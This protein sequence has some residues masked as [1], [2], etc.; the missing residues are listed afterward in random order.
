[1]KKKKNNKPKVKVDLKK[2]ANAIRKEEGKEKET[3][4]DS[5][6]EEVSELESEVMDNVPVNFDEIRRNFEPV[7][8]PVLEPVEDAPRE[9]R[10]VR[11]DFQPILDGR[12]NENENDLFR[13][14]IQDKEEQPKYVSPVSN[15]PMNTER[16]NFLEV[17]RNP[18]TPDERINQKE[19]FMSSTDFINNSSSN[20][21]K[22]TMPSNVDFEK[23]GRER[24]FEKQTKKYDLTKDLPK[25]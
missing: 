19:M 10:V 24:P 22:Y 1:M 17:G 7:R 15:T 11:R 23:V 21:E 5:T 9:E 2:L 12:E 8:A 4:E 13:Y 3:S 6:D 18:Q 25:H 20:I 16:I 14:N